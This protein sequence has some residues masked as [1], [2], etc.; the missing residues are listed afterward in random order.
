MLERKSVMPRSFYSFFLA[1]S[2]VFSS[3]RAAPD[4]SPI[5][6]P[7]IG[8]FKVLLSRSPL[9]VLIE[10][11]KFEGGH[12]VRALPVESVKLGKTE[13]WLVR[14]AKEFKNAP[15]IVGYLNSIGLEPVGYRELLE[16]TI[17]EP[18]LLAEGETVYA[19]GSPAAFMCGTVSWQYV[20]LKDD[21]R[22]VSDTVESEGWPAN[23]YYLA[24]QKPAK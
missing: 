24:K 13:L 9:N 14:P 1:F 7:I 3:A 18:K 23:A 12:R 4:A 10:R 21:R 16:F 8:K 5:I 17:Q 2:L 15:E 22:F 20:G 11:G 6:H 19:L